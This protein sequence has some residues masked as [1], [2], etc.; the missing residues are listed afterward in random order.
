RR[1]R[2]ETAH[3]PL[4]DNRS[5]VPDFRLA[6]R[7]VA[8][9]S[10][11]NPGHVPITL[12]LELK[13]D[14]AF[15]DPGLRPIRGSELDALDTVIRAELGAR[16]LTPDE[17]RGG[18][19]TLSRAIASRGWP[20]LGAVRGRIVVILHEDETFRKLYV[21]GHPTLEGRAMFTCAPFDAP[22]GGVA[23]CDDPV[24][25]ASR[26]GTAL[27]RH[28]IVRTRADGDGARGQAGLAA[29]LGSGA[30][31]V[32]TDFPP[33]YPA[34]DGYVASFAGGKLIEVGQGR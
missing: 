32:S 2:F 21:A 13:T 19:E 3:V 30:Q 26:I 31:I 15:L 27:A 9:W 25:D 10:D 23:I 29:A 4:V 6:L 8:A 16:L 22:D 24:A 33:A 18:A 14:Y 20:R 1:G 7:E 17:V 34:P 12:L 28:W 11:R 5:T